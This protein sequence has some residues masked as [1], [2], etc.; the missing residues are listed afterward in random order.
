MSPKNDAPDWTEDTAQNFLIY[1]LF[2]AFWTRIVGLF[3]REVAVRN[4]HL[5][6]KSGPIIFV[7]APHHNQFVD[8][9][10]LLMHASRRVYYLAAAASMRRKFIGFYGRCLRGIPV[11]RQQ[12]LAKSGAGKIRLDDRYAEPTLIT[13]IN[14]RFT[15]QLKVGMKILLP[16]NA[17]QARVDEIISDTQLRTSNEMKE[18][19]ALEAL[20]QSEGTPYKIAPHIDQDEMYRAVY[21]RLNNGEC[22]GI[23]PEGGSHDRTEMLPLKAGATIMALGATAANPELGLKIVPTGLNYFHPS[24]FRSRAVIDFGQPIDIP[25]DLVEK[26][27]QGGDAKRQACN[28]LLEVVTDGLKQVTLNTPDY[29]TLK[30]IQ[31]GRRLY[32]PTQHSLTMAQQVELTRRFIKGYNVYRDLPEVKE[33]R[34]RVEDYNMQLRYYGIRDHQVETMQIGRAQAGALFLWRLLW[35]LIMGLVALPGIVLNI[36]VF[37]VTGVVSKRKAKAALAASTVKVRARD[38]IAT[39]KILIALVLVP[40]LYSVYSVLAAVFVR[41]APVWAQPYTASVMGWPS[42]AIYLCS[43]ALVS[44]MSYTALVFGEQAI[45]I[46]KSIRP[47]FLTLILGQEHTD[48]LVAQREDLSND[49]TELVNE[50]GPKIYPEFSTTRVQDHLG[51]DKTTHSSIINESADA[52]HRKMRLGEQAIRQRIGNSARKTKY[53]TRSGPKYKFNP[54]TP[55]TMDQL[56][57]ISPLEF[58]ISPS[59]EDAGTSGR[60]LRLNGDSQGNVPSATGTSTPEPQKGLFD[61]S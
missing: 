58:L 27:R 49:I 44:L 39:W 22:I 3:F 53:P 56:N 30:L 9:I 32:Q 18:L 14:T 52:F 7:V 8:P 10:I 42:F 46:V 6:P 38:V 55:S 1:D 51:D 41:R 59:T 28:E 11:E 33:L 4:S 31:A 29:E 43:W 25:A 5:I 37:I 21:Q 17:G 61:I 16:K 35:L 2:R 45:D 23:F 57:S 12:D 50:L 48:L 13:G 34:D 19:E 54:P 60:K 26:Y 24:K 15:E 47:L 40:L 20:T 36:P